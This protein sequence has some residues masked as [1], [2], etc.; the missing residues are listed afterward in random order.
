[1]SLKEKHIEIG[2]TMKPHGLKGEMKFWVEEDFVEDLEEADVILLDLKGKL[3]PFFVEQVRVGNAIIVKLEDVNTP[4]AAIQ[5]GGKTVFLRERDILTDEQRQRPLEKSPYA[6]CIGYDIVDMQDGTPQIAG[7]IVEIVELPQSEM[8][9]I[10][11]DGREVLVPL[12]E[13][14][15]KEIKHSTQQIIVELPEGLLDL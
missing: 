15:V 11:R 10:D 7:K 8:A 13:A 9:V 12:I 3:T 5:V 4:E 1:M 2:K 14:F 6:R